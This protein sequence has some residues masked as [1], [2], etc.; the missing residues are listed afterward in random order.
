MATVSFNGWPYIPALIW[1]VNGE[2]ST[3]SPRK[4]PASPTPVPI[5]LRSSTATTEY[6]D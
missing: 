6:S 5:W 4:V 1:T 2:S 3:S